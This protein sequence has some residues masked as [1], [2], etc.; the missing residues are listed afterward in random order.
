MQTVVTLLAQLSS[1]AL[2]VMEKY[3]GLSGGEPLIAHEIGRSMGLGE[4]RVIEVI[5]HRI[6]GS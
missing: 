2:E 4:D 6:C 1:D 3:F 5:G